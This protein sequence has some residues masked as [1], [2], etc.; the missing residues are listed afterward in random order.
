MREPPSDVTEAEVLDV[1]RNHWGLDAGSL[2]HL[3]VGCGA[4][5]WRATGSTHDWFVTLDA[6]LP[7]HTAVTLE[8]AYA[9]AAT[10]AA[11]GLEFVLSGRP[12]IGGAFTA[13]FAGHAVSVTPWRDGSPGDGS[14]TVGRA[15][16][17]RGWLDRLHA[18]APP[19]GLSRWRPLVE[20][21]L[22]DELATRTQRPGR[23][24][25][26]GEQARTALGA[27]LREIEAWVEAYHRLAADTDERTWV[28]THGEPH[29]RNQLDTPDGTLLVD[30]ESLKLAPRERDLR[31]LVE[32]GHLQPDADQAMLTMF[33][34]EWRLDEIR[35]Y[36][37]WFAGPHADTED[38][39][40]ALGGL[41]F[42]L[43]RA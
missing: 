8:A 35:Q 43:E 1:L 25:P 33:D 11:G 3:P 7:R 42:E 26:H 36:A 41:L 34:L 30:W 6:L 39:R 18:A 17:T 23:D 15:T 37:D 40:I 24:G 29:T 13:P 22:G 4:H 16:A 32:A 38:D 5:H 20:A 19:P 2:V 14:M 27:R 21:D 10:L 28:A 9:G 12:A 31:T